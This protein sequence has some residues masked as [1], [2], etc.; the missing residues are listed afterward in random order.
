MR[1]HDC[2]VEVIEVVMV[3]PKRATF[4]TS[5]QAKRKKELLV[6]M[7]V[8]V[9]F[10]VLLV[11]VACYFVGADENNTPPFCLL[12]LESLTTC[13]PMLERSQLVNCQVTPLISS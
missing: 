10:C 9:I 2:G 7:L 4:S 11:L 5:L 8:C 6:L 12:S 13:H 1:V 3:F